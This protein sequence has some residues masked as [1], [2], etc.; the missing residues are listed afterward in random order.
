MADTA[1]Q[2][3]QVLNQAL[4]SNPDARK[5][6]EDLLESLASQPGFGHALVHAS[7]RQARR[8]VTQ[9]HRSICR[10]SLSYNLMQGRNVVSDLDR[11]RLDNI[12]TSTCMTVLQHDTNVQDLTV[13]HRQL[14]ALVLKRLVKERWDRDSKHFKPPDLSSD[15]K[16]AIKRDLVPGLA[17][18]QTKIRVAIGMVIA[19]EFHAPFISSQHA[20]Y[21]GPRSAPSS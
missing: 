8:Y 17:D 12:R 21:T 3:I 2:I 10:F 16:S 4:D 6:G 19:G 1:S 20:L 11:S 18:P 5:Q 14:A 9:L 13:G 15:E 7:L